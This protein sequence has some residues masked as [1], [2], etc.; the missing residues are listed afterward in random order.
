M[1]DF[2][3]SQVFLTPVPLCGTMGHAEREFAA[4]LIIRA[5]QVNGD[6]WHAVTTQE[7]G[8]MIEAIQKDRAADPWLFDFLT[9]P[10]IKFDVYEL[11]EHA[12]ARWTGE[13]GKSPVELTDR[14][15]EAARYWV[16]AAA[17]DTAKEG[18]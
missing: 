11:V 1:P 16:K 2:K 4:A 7:I 5:C 6:T 8:R 9:N 10:F 12:Y 14:A 15:F 18:T 17:P 13:P 3:P